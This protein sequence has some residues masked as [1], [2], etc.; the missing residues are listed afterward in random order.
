MSSPIKVDN[1]KKYLLLLAKCPTHG[2]EHTLSAEE[3]YSINFTKKKKKKF[4]LNLHYDKENSYLGW[5]VDNM[6]K[7]GL[8]GYIYYFS[9]DY[10][11]IAVDDILGIHEYLM[12]KN[13]I[14]KCLDLL[15][16]GLLYLYHLL[17]ELH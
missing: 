7:T 17:V 16:K 9:V 11:T 2:L 5:S 8:N 14:K 1:K 3:L 10:D 4:S 6:K 13:N 15:K 12:K